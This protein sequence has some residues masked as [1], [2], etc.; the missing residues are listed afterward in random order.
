[1]PA[2]DSD[3]PAAVVRRPGGYLLDAEADQVDRR[4]GEHLGS[5]PSSSARARAA[6]PAS[7][8]AAAA[9]FDSVVLTNT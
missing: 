1:M 6:C 7:I 8:L 9:A 3:R 2:A 4:L 5:R